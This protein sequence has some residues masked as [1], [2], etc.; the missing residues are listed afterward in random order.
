MIIPDDIHPT[1]TNRDTLD[2]Q[3]FM[4]QREKLFMLN[5]IAIKY[6]SIVS[7]VVVNIYPA[8]P[9]IDYRFEEHFADYAILVNYDWHPSGRGCENAS[10]YDTYPKGN[11]CSYTDPVTVFPSGEF[12]D[13]VACQPACYVKKRARKLYATIPSEKS[14]VD[15]DDPTRCVECDEDWLQQKTYDYTRKRNLAGGYALYDW[16]SGK[17]VEDNLPKYKAKDKKE[18]DG[19]ATPDNDPD[20]SQVIWDGETKQCI[21]VNTPIF[22]TVVEPYWADKSHSK[23]RVTNFV[24]GNDIVFGFRPDYIGEIDPHDLGFLVRNSRTY[25]RAFN[26]ELKDGGNC[27]ISL[28]NQILSYTLAGETM[29]NIVRDA[30]S[31]EWTCADDHWR[32]IEGERTKEVDLAKISRDGGNATFRQWRA[33]VNLK[34]TLPP[35]NVKL[36][37]LGIDVRVTGNRLYWNNVE[38]IVSQF[39]MFR[40]IEQLIIDNF[41]ETTNVDD[42]SLSS[43]DD[44]KSTRRKR[45]Y[46]TE[47]SLARANFL[48]R[49]RNY[50][51]ADE[52]ID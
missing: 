28:F 10:C 34:F 24:H 25:C 14:L 2:A 45:R 18:S 40:T 38:G 35:T 33:N 41:Y 37:D 48:S 20:F 44:D 30:F 16:K 27:E 15:D 17:T 42:T 49:Y 5:K 19:D 3:V 23:C 7:W 51:I 9:Q 43:N 39:A 4:N 31:G 50:A 46:I 13:V 47:E 21:L 1:Y 8:N 11:V 32:P 12:T 6:P 29:L 52:G 22:R 36:S 26:K